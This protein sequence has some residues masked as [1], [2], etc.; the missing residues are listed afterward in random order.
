[1]LSESSLEMLEKICYVSGKIMKIIIII[2]T[3]YK[4][5]YP[6]KELMLKALGGRKKNRKS[7]TNN[8]RRC[9]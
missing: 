3:I 6:F 4:A 1:M 5:P 8:T 2:L 9:T 7:V